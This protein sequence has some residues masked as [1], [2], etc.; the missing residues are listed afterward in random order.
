MYD[1][2][3]R[4]SQFAVVFEIKDEKNHMQTVC[5]IRFVLQGQL[6]FPVKISIKSMHVCNYD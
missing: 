6:G 3:W 4:Y 2:Y 5:C 1:Y